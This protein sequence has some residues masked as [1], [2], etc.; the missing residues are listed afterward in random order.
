MAVFVMAVVMALLKLLLFTSTCSAEPMSC[1]AKFAQLEEKFD[2]TI[3]AF[4]KKINSLD[5]NVHGL[6]EENNHLMKQL[7]ALDQSRSR[8][9][10]T[11][12]GK[13]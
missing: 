6:E 1:E 4:T 10:K 7:A 8:F 2:R 13:S 12:S 11:R 9:N 3:N 5:A